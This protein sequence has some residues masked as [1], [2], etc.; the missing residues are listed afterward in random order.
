M[1]L[2]PLICPQCGGQITNYP[3][4]SRSVTCDY[5]STK[6]QIAHNDQPKPTYANDPP[7]LEAPSH[8]TASPNV[9]IIVAGVLM[10]LLGAVILISLLNSKKRDVRAVNNVIPPVPRSTSTGVSRKVDPGCVLSFGEGGTGDGQFQEANSIAVDKQGRIYVGDRT[11]RVQQFD[12]NGQYL[13]TIQ[14]PEKGA[15]YKKARHIDKISVAADGRIFIA[16]GGVILVYDNKTKVPLKT[17]QVAPDYIQDFALRGDGG[18]LAISD[19]NDIETLLFVNGS[20]RITRRLRGFHTNALDAAVSPRETALA[21]IRLATDGKSSIYSVYAFG[22]LGNYSI[23]SN[24]DELQIARY[25][26][27]GKFEKSFGQSMNSCGIEADQK[28]RLFLS[29]GM[30]IEIFDAEGRRIDVLP[31][32]ITVQAFAID[33]TDHVFAVSEDRVVEKVIPD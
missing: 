18:L 3:P 8:G 25:T 17:I 26:A 20:G 13:K 1:D 16:V 27:D 5:C 21:A 22:D 31:L 9:G 28:G 6:I 19:S 23:T 4:G 15:N 32:D 12:P 2:K 14:V 11:L 33:R 29:N 10:I 30:T 24:H 7:A